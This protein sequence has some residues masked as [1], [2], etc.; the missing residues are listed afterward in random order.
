M[1][2]TALFTPHAWESFYVIVGTT[3][4]ALIGLQFVVLTLISEAGMMRGTSAT[5]S[6]FASPNVVHFCAA[7]GVP[8]LSARGGPGAARCWPPWR[9]PE[10]RV[11]YSVRRPEA[12]LRQ[13]VTSRFEDWI[14]HAPLPSPHTRAG[15]RRH[16]A[17]AELRRCAV[18]RRGRMLLVF[19]G[20]TTPGT[21]DVVMLERAR[22][23]RPS[24]LR[25]RPPRDRPP[26]DTLRQR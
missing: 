21:R 25:P 6:A 20:S 17:L 11:I 18:H 9:W 10:W 3:A 12:A 19:V 2:E 22:N 14:W 1:D 26:R 24:G 13:R 16:P 5:L 4:G 8:I 7:L 23:A 15:A